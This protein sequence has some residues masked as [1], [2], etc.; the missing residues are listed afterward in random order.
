MHCVAH[1]VMPTP[2]LTL[3][4]ASKAAQGK[5]EAD[6]ES[7]TRGHR[8]LILVRRSSAVA[9]ASRYSKVVGEESVPACPP[10]VP[11]PRLSL[12]LCR[13]LAVSVGNANA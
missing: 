12:R 7:H 6:D 9:L 10:E 13:M 5:P 1:T 11:H 4:A 2:S 8:A 3:G